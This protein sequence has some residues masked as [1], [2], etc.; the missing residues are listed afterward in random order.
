MTPTDLPPSNTAKRERRLQQYR[1]Y[2]RR[3]REKLRDQAAGGQQVELFLPTHLAEELDRQAEAAGLSRHAY[4]AK[5]VAGIA[6][7]TPAL[8]Q[9]LFGEDSL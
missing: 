9:A 2:Q 7:A 3:R 1:D 8:R 4:V 5:L 6:Q